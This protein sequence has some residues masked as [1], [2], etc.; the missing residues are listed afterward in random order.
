M[1]GFNIVVTDSSGKPIPGA[2]ISGAFLGTNPGGGGN[3][4]VD[5]TTDSNGFAQ[6]EP[7]GSTGVIDATISAVGYQDLAWQYGSP[8]MQLPDATETVF[9]API[10]GGTGGSSGGLTGGPGGSKTPFKPDTTAITY[11]VVAI[12]VVVVIIIL[13]RYRKPIFGAAKKGV[14]GVAKFAKVGA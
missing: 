10:T 3:A 8:F 1:S 2:T 14:S 5:A 9:L 4:T 13:I 11:I 12:V 6:L 7:T